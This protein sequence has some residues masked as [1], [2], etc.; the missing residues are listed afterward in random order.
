MIVIRTARGG[1]IGLINKDG[2]A[3]ANH[4]CAR[5][6]ADAWHKFRDK[7]Y[8][9][10]GNL[11]KTRLFE[12][13]GLRNR[14]GVM[15]GGGNIFGRVRYERIKDHVRNTTVEDVCTEEGIRSKEQI[16]ALFGVVIT[17]VEY[18]KLRDSIKYIRNKYK[19]EWNLR[20]LGKSIV[21]H[22][23]GNDKDYLRK[24]PRVVW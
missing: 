10:D 1:D 6:I 12:N 23:T 15:L 21:R 7:L 20:E 2:I 3:K 4:P 5:G 16:I 9:N 17:D 13:P 24:I 19:P 11:F 14:M 8:E 22:V 18:G